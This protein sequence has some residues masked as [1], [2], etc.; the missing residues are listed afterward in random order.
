MIEKISFFVY[1]LTCF[2]GLLLIVFLC[3]EMNV[4]QEKGKLKSP[5]LLF[6]LATLLLAVLYFIEGHYLYHYMP[7]LKWNSLEGWDGLAG[8]SIT[9]RIL[10]ILFCMA[11]LFFWFQYLQSELKLVKGKFV[12]A[13]DLIL[14][15]FTVLIGTIHLALMDEHYYVE[16]TAQRMFSVAV[17]LAFSLTLLFLSA[18][19]LIFIKRAQMIK[20]KK[21]YLAFM[22]IIILINA[23]W[24]EGFTYLL[25]VKS[26]ILESVGCRT[27]DLIS[28][29][30]LLILLTSGIWFYKTSVS[31]LFQ[32]GGKAEREFR[33]EKV[34]GVSEE[35]GL[36]ER[37]KEVV[38]LLLD[39]L[40][41]DTIAEQLYIS[42]YTVKRHTH[43]IYK[44]L[45]VSTRIELIK[46]FE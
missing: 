29:L 40:S 28:I 4:R 39:G 2:A 21:M 46:R 12:Y 7:L 9:E 43:N 13:T 1:V 34:L 41:Y 10:D 16:N 19:Y 27:F 36:T 31:R 3:L 17:E 22:S 6:A 24:N 25:T 38:L 26:R 45:E 35:F 15:L 8:W 42:K 14:V 11:H 30:L 20:G 37:E 18:A 5:F 32:N 44:K 33:R 23:L